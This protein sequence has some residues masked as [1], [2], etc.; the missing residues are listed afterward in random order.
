MNPYLSNFYFHRLSTY[1]QQVELIY[2]YCVASFDFY[3]YVWLLNQGTNRVRLIFAA[4][5]NLMK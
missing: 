2:Y 3:S 1:C 4:Y 5:D